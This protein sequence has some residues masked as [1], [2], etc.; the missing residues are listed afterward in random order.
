MG[1]GNV[2]VTGPYEGLYY[3]DNDNFHV[4]RD[5][6]DYG[7]YPETRLLQ[8]LEYADISSGPWVFDEW[9]TA[10]EQGDIE[11]CF[12]ENFTQMFPSFSSM[13]DLP[14][15]WV[16]NGP[17]GDFSRR[18]LMESKLFY[19]CVE[20][21]EWSLAVELIQKEDP[22]DDHLIGLQKRHFQK[23]LDGIKKCLL[24]RLPRIGTHTGAWTS[25]THTAEEFFA[26]E[27]RG[28]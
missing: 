23:Y 4:Y 13:K 5:S 27:N 25:G 7:D 11:E 8:D 2:C 20:D 1:R 28:E 12:I 18:V 15:K 19:V 24:S 16:R 21:N 14:D 6:D 17:C 26:A 3:I 22:Y 9:G 10:E